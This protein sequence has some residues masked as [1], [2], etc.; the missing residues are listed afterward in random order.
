M[1]DRHRDVALFRYSLIR[2]AAT[3]STTEERHPPTAV[4]LGVRPAR[5]RWI[6]RRYCRYPFSGDA[7]HPTP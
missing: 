3:T 1:D 5:K 6:L 2:E 7:H 4:R